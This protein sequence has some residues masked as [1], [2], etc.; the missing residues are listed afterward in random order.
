MGGERL[1]SGRR[2]HSMKSFLPHPSGSPLRS[3]FEH[4]SPRTLT[5]SAA[6]SGRRSRQAAAKTGFSGARQPVP[7][8]PAAPRPRAPLGGAGSRRSGCRRCG[9]GP[10][11]GEPLGRGG[12]HRATPRSARRPAAAETPRAPRA[13]APPR[14][15]GASAGGRGL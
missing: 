9:P 1:P 13:L 2:S 12:S 14:R 15:A 3:I 5:L 4:L 11:T 8:S 7:A 10:G 6:C